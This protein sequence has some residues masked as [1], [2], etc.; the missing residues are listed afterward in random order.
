VEV[1]VKRSDKAGKIKGIAFILTM[2]VI[3]AIALRDGRSVSSANIV[4]GTTVAN[5]ASIFANVDEN[6]CATCH[7]KVVREFGRTPHGK[8]PDKWNIGKSNAG[9][10]P[11]SASCVAC[12]GN[13][14]EHINSGGDP[15]KIKNPA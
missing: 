14:T 1:T 4:E 3:A 12:H 10:F 8:A 15:T 5:S 13:P 2:L 11:D 7:E 6:T 9:D